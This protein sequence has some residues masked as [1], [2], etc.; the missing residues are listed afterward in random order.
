MKKFGLL[1][2]TFIGLSGSIFAQQSWCGTDSRLNKTFLENPTYVQQFIEHNSRITSGQTVG[3][4]RTDPIIIP[5]VV[6]VIHDNGIGNISNEQIQSGIDMLN[7]DYNRLNADTIDTRNTTNAPFE[8][9]A[10]SFDI[11]FALAKLD[12][13][14]NCTNGI[15]RRNSALGTYNAGEN[16]KYYAEGGLDAWP[17]D[18]YMN[19]WIVN[20]IEND[21]TAGITLG[22]AQFPQFADDGY[23]VIIRHD[24]YGNVGTASG[25]RTLTHEIGHCLG[26][27]HT[28]Q[29]P[30][31]GGGT[32]CHTTDCGANGDFCCD[33]PPA[34]ASHWDCPTTY[35]SCTSVPA[36]DFYAADVYDQ[37]ENY[38]SYAPCQNMFSLGQYNIVSTNLTDISFLADLVSLSNQTATGILSPNVLC[39]ASF[40]S[41]TQTICAGN[42]ISF[43]DASYFNVTG[44]NWTFAGGTASST[45]D[46]NPTV[47]YNTPGSY[48]VSLEV[49]DGISTV[50]IT[51]ANYI[52]VLPAPGDSYPYK[53]SFESLVSIPDNDRF[54]ITNGNSGT[55]WELTSATAY[56]GTDCAFLE[57]YGVADGSSDE[58]ISG[59]IDLS[60][61][62]PA[63]PIVFNFKYAYKRKVTANDEWLR[64]YVSKDCGQTWALRKNIHGAALGDVQ[65]GAFTPIS[66]D[67]WKTVDIT[68]IT[69]DYYVADFRYKIVFENDGGNNMYIDNIN[70]YPAS[71]TGIAV[72]EPVT[73]FSLYPNPAQN[74]I[75]ISLESVPQNHCEISLYDALGNLV[76]IVYS[77]STEGG[78]N[79]FD[80]STGDLPAGIY[81]IRITG[82]TFSNEKKLIKQ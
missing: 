41:N 81:F 8:P 43:T 42:T 9:I 67:E 16:A 22:Y 66:A 29:G 63:D 72:L 60:G 40:Y 23:G 37:W 14:G 30:F 49:T 65:S 32:G 24:S 15:E 20:S 5:V 21:G 12:P 36:N 28:F 7:I 18:Q 76:A 74:S 70:L 79:S 45:T 47:T 52:L 54:L 61:V 35:N 71:M 33:T 25:D 78:L 73:T 75:T 48:D 59:T 4:D 55:T 17:R 58:L 38:M 2:A 26:L 1:A 31:F 6:H 57:N 34:S 51:L 82:D 68:N 53:E 46:Q 3:A 27:L 19:I 77:G 44:W 56:S 39:E 64:F 80:Y 62:D 69:S 10:V 11:N 13:D 50:S